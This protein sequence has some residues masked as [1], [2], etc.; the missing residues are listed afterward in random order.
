[1]RMASLGSGSRGNATLVESD[2]TC[3]LIDLGF[4]VK[5]TVRRLTR[6]NRSPEDISAILVTHEHADHIGGVAQ[7][8]RKFDIPVYMTP[9]TH[10]AMKSGNV[11]TLKRVNCHRQFRVGD[12]NVE[13]VPVPHDAR[14]PCQ[15]L[16]SC[17]G[18]RVGILT[19]LGHITPFVEMQYSRC[20]ALL[21]EC[22]HDPQMLIDGPYSWPLKKRV[23]GEHGHLS[24]DQ[25]AGLLKTM[26]LSSLQHLVLSHIS[27]QNNLPE[28]AT[29]SLRPVLE[30]W[31]GT[32]HVANQDEGFGWISLLAS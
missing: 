4:S 24:N 31:G 18:K 28:L 30:D 25:A 11:P 1:M 17:A 16:L 8:A 14:E 26:E 9:G 2:A 23:G 10:S 13:P 20:D 29:Q 5:E 7:F 12:I 32:L 21:L 19:D 27:Q 22:N 15:Y 3:L 6:L